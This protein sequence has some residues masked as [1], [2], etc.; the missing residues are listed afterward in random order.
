MS[1]PKKDYYAILGL[2]KDADES[3]LK[4]AYYKLAQKWHP[5]KNPENKKEAEE[6]FKEIT[7]AYGILSDPQK[8][9]HYDQFGMCDGEVPDFSHGF[10][11][12]SELFGGG[13]PFGQMGGMGGF[14]FGQMGGMNGMGGMG[15]MGGMRGRTEQNSIQEVKVKLK[16]SEIYGGTNKSIDITINDMCGG[17]EGT[18]SKTKS[19]ENCKT[20]QGRGI[21]IIIRQM[22]PNMVAQQQVPCDV[23][24]Q[25]GTTINPKDICAGCNGKCTISTKLNKVLNI[26]KNFDYETII[27]LKN[28]GNYDPDTK[29]K[30]NI[31][32]SFKISDL[33]KYN[34][35]MKNSHDLVLEQ[36]INIGEALSGYSMYWDSHPD[37]NKYHFK[38]HDVIKDKDV[39]FV[40]NLGLPCNDNNK[41]TRGKLYIRFNYIYPS[42]ILETD[43]LKQFIKT[44]EIKNI[45]DKDSWIKEKIYDIK[46]DINKSNNNNHNS[47]VNIEGDLPNCTQS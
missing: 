43:M 1:N 15:G 23:C 40:K 3:S 42:S 9:Q 28:S 44:K 38:I 29:L 41:L 10:P 7:E 12:L 25:K 14:P 8:K 46:D 17:C 18:G 47:N 19:R 34:L 33:D 27:L 2:S 36:P 37:G 16:L 30:A 32:I 13:F 22:G 6:K 20:C 45:T 39:K 11:D 31:N 26:T 24:N 21:R 5:D 4:K 35:E